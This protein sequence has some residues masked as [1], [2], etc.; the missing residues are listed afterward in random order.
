[1]VHG[2]VGCSV[3]WG[4]E[5][6]SRGLSRSEVQA[7]LAGCLTGTAFLNSKNMTPKINHSSDER[8]RPFG[9]RIRLYT[10]YF[11]SVFTERSAERSSCPHRLGRFGMVCH[12][13]R[14]A[15]SL[16]RRKSLNEEDDRFD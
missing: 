12:L 1:M 15:E 9:K 8:E 5:K 11:E 7:C 3:V 2:I 14:S 16:R 13:G 4:A 10:L 6:G